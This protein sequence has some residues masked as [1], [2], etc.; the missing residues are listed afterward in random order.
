MFS[1][2]DQNK[3]SRGNCSV[4]WDFKADDFLFL[5]GNSLNGEIVKPSGENIAP[6]NHVVNKNRI[7]PGDDAH[8]WGP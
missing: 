6:L 3:S 7:P 4:Q 5:D 2:G 1:R 8:F